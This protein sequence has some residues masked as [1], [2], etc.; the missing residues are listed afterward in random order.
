MPTN[1]ANQAA[2][3]RTCVWKPNGGWGKSLGFPQ[4][5]WQST[6]IAQ[7]QHSV[8][9]ASL[10][11]INVTLERQLCIDTMPPTPLPKRGKYQI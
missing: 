9:S 2:F 7:A 5:L 1:L 3:R 11:E 4:L 6:H 8:S 10:Q